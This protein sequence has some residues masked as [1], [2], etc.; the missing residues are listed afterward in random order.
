MVAANSKLSYESSFQ[1]CLVEENRKKMEALNLP[2]IALQ[3]HRSPV[4]VEGV[5]MPGRTYHSNRH[6]DQKLSQLMETQNSILKIL[7]QTLL[8]FLPSTWPVLL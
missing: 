3:A 2:Q 5:L 8:I 7:S 1:Q 6:K 4:F